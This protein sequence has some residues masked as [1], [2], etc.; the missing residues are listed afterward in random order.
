MTPKLWAAITHCTAGHPAEGNRYTDA[1]RRERCHACD[2][3]S[4]RKALAAKRQAAA[5]T[6]A[7]K[8]ELAGEA[9][10]RLDA[11]LRQ[12]LRSA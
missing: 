4:A 7:G 9:L 1:Q 12:R 6:I 8:G 2:Q 10:S 3:V 11:L 5:L